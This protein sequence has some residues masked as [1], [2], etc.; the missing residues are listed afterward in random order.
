ME[1][2][3]LLPLVSEFSIFLLIFFTLQQKNAYH[4]I[5]LTFTFSKYPYIIL[6]NW[7]SMYYYAFLLGLKE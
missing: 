5:S 7:F 2:S 1:T 4:F 6:L 3:F